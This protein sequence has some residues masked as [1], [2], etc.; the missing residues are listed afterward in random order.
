MNKGQTKFQTVLEVST[1]TGSGILLAYWIAQALSFFEPQI[2]MVWSEFEFHIGYKTNMITTP[3]F[4]L[5][6]VVRGLLWRRFFNWAMLIT[7]EG[8][9]VLSEL[10]NKFRG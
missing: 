3:I 7:N 6:S 1:N 5:A 9:S 8:K 2:Q 10:R 4:T